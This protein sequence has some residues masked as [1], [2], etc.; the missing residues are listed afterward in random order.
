MQELDFAELINK[1]AREAEES[2]D[3]AGGGKD[4]KL[5]RKAFIETDCPA[6]AIVS[7]AEVLE[8]RMKER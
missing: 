1:L 7:L 3:Y 4:K 5:M 2:A 8:I 6:F